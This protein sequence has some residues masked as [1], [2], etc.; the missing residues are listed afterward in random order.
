MSATTIKPMRL[1]ARRT[2]RKDQPRGNWGSPTTSFMPLLFSAVCL[3]PIVYIVL[4]GFRTNAQITAA[5]AGFPSPWQIGNYLD[6]LTG[7]TF[8]QE[9]GNS[10]IAGLSTTIG[11][12]V[13]G[14]MVSFVLARY[15]FAGRGAMYALFA[16][17]L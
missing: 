12:V 4:G 11:V 5:P 10:V 7:S 15:R 16:A 6:V 17:G 3:T 8:W 14:V 1:D 2:R 13:L 9:V